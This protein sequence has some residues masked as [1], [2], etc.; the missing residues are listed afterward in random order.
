VGENALELGPQIDFARDAV[1]G[2]PFL[3]LIGTVWGVMDA[4]YRSKPKAGAAQI[5]AADGTRAVS[6]RAHPPPDPRFA[7]A[8]PAIGSATTFGHAQTRNDRC[9]IGY[10]SP[11]ELASGSNTSFVD[12]AARER[13]FRRGDG[14]YSAT[15]KPR[16]L[17][18][19]NLRHCST[20]LRFLSFS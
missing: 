14:R 6:G 16:S 10:I 18:E 3:G 2:S 4:I 1:S 11:A 13:P 9:E 20:R 15:A 12:H 17:S 19:I 5:F 8:I 7:V